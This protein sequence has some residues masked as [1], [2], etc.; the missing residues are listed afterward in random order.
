MKTIEEHLTQYAKY[1][2]DPRNIM[3]HLVGVPMIVLSIILLLSKTLFTA[4]IPFSISLI[5]IVVSSLYYLKLHLL[6]GVSMVAYMVLAYWV[7]SLIRVQFENV[8]VFIAIGL[9]VVGWIIQFWGHMFEGKKPAF[10]DDLMG[11]LIG[12][13][14]VLAECFFMVGGL[15]SLQKEIEQGAGI[16]EIRG[17]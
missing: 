7:S 16:V 17:K 9:F 10:V 2:R 5:L 13:V 8:W 14:F 11:L 1:H 4:G 3:T 12:P 15:K 6:L